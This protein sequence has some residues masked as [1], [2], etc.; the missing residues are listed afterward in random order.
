LEKQFGK[1]LKQNIG[2]IS[3]Q[4]SG[5]KIQEKK[6]GKQDLRT[7]LGEKTFGNKN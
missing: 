2:E 4:K 3:K 7:N 6:F 1:K 5:T